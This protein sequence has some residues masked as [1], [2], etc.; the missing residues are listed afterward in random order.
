MF[1]SSAVSKE[2]SAGLDEVERDSAGYHCRSNN[3][4]VAQLAGLEDELDQHRVRCYA[5]ESGQLVVNLAVL[6]CLEMCPVEYNVELEGAM[7]NCMSSLC[8]LLSEV[9]LAGVEANDHG[10]L[11]CSTLDI[12]DCLLSIVGSDADRLRIPNVS[13]VSA[14]PCN[15]RAGDDALGEYSLQSLLLLP[16]CRDHQSVPL[17]HRA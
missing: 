13:L 14:S 5:A 16:R 6:S 12:V 8:H 1:H 4:G 3:L 15:C 11:D 7:G 10:N 2:A 9:V 17:L